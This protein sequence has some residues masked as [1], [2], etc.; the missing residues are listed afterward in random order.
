[1]KAKYF[2]LMLGLSLALVS[3][4]TPE[5]KSQNSTSSRVKN[6]KYLYHLHGRIIEDMGP[7]KA[8]SEK[9][10]KYAYKEILKTFEDAGFEVISEA[11]PKDT[12]V[13]K[14]STRLTNKIKEQIKSGVPAENITVV[15][16]SKGSLIA[17]LTS[18]KLA[19]KKVKFVIMANCNKWVQEN[20]EIDLH[21]K[22][23]SIYEKSDTIG[24]NSCEDIKTN[25]KGIT[26]YK[27]IEINTGLDHGFLYKP[28]NQWI[29]P[30]IKWA[31]N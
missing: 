13:K 27:E 23:L 26:K 5:I 22:I 29:E 17:M 2:I 7:E 16:A 9:F 21:G 31:K 1:M 15:G 30:T 18:T 25:S 20:F 24:G 3:C 10:G 28:L 4:N 11:R 6:K 12:D 8:F 14:Y 19:N